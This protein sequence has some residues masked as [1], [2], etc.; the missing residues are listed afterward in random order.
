MINQLMQNTPARVNH[1][2]V[3]EARVT[4]IMY[5]YIWIKYNRV[6]VPWATG[7]GIRGLFKRVNLDM[8]NGTWV[9]C[10]RGTCRVNQ[11]TMNGVR[12]T[13][14]VTWLTRRVEQ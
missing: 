3:N 12:G 14:T 1:N 10:H 11:L 7:H 8:V 4:F 9:L 2:T 5:W 13:F 6:N